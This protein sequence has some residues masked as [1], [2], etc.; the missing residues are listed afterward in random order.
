MSPI[1]KASTLALVGVALLLVGCGG[2][3]NSNANPNNLTQ[4]Q[5][6]QLGSETFADAYEALEDVAGQL[7]A[8]SDSGR[9]SD[10]LEALSKN[11]N[12]P[13]AMTPDGVSCSDTTCTI[14]AVVYDCVDGGTITINGS[15][16]ESS[17]SASL[18]LTFV[19]ASCSDGT[20]VINGNPNLTMNAQASDN[21][22][23]T[24]VSAS[25][26]GDIS[27]SPVQ[28]GQFPT[29]SCGSNLS[30]NVS[31]SDSTGS[32]TSCSVS[33]AM[34]GQTVNVSSCP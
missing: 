19:P 9:K 7:P 34:C 20:L 28:T 24:T 25:I 12:F 29:G 5:A 2:S 8:S 4:P 17:S 1:S 10:P 11:K 13:S 21:G 22:T 14:T 15:G 26:D 27:F 23:T 16:S 6:Q 30:I 18:D 3:S 31:V 33:G 32:L